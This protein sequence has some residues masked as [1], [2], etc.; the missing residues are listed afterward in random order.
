MQD[1]PLLSASSLT[2]SI[3]SSNIAVIY[4][5]NQKKFLYLNAMKKKRH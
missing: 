4:L 1:D 3:H 2:K 5:F